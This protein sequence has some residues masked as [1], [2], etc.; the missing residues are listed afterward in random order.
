MTSVWADSELQWEHYTGSLSSASIAFR[1]L[2]LMVIKVLLCRISLRESV[3][4]RPFSFSICKDLTIFGM[5]NRILD[6]SVSFSPLL[7]FYPFKNMVGL[8]IYSSFVLG[9]RALFVSLFLFWN[10]VSLYSLGWPG[11]LYI[12]QVGFKLIQILSL[13]LPHPA[14]SVLHLRQ[15][16]YIDCTGLKPIILLPRPLEYQDWRHMPTFL[17]LFLSL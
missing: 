17:T 5:E 14:Y 7:Y 6:N 8:D 12:N 4:L 10:R 2:Q 13:P 15:G 3:N 11:I 1:L 16:R 9:W